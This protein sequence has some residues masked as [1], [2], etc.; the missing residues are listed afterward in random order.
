[1]LFFR[2]RC[3]VLFRICHRGRRIRVNERD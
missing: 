3:L 2:F 1:V